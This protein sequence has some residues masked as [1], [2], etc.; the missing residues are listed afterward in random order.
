MLAGTHARAVRQVGG[1]IGTGTGGVADNL[2]LSVGN[3][4]A[5]QPL[6]LLAAALETAEPGQ[7]IALVVLADGWDVFL[8][9]VTDAIAA[10]RPARARSPAR[11]RPAA[12]PCP[13]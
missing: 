11:S 3:A 5:A 1:K 6:L 8:F 4:G 12:T 2:A 10:W 9:R 13:T 7:V